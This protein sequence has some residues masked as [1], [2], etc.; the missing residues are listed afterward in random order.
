MPGMVAGMIVP[1]AMVWDVPRDTTNHGR[2][3]GSYGGYA[4]I[5]PPWVPQVSL[6]LGVCHQVWGAMGGM[7]WGMGGLE[8]VPRATF[9]PGPG[10]LTQETA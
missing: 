1:T 5:I 4:D 3:P 7:D 9:C 2:H 10:K 6:S 8:I